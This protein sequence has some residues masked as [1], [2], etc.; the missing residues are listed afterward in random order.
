MQNYSEICYSNTMTRVNQVLS[1]IGVMTITSQE[2]Y[3]TGDMD[4]FIMRVYAYLELHYMKSKQIV[5]FL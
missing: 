3:Y 1:N 4:S 2:L 5:N